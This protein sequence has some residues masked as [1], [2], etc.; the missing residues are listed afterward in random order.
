MPSYFAR[1][2]RYGKLLV[3][4][5]NRPIPALGSDS[6]R[7]NADYRHLGHFRLSYLHAINRLPARQIETDP[8]RT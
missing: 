7:K 8:E 4:I 3:I 2:V 6:T 5:G 1:P